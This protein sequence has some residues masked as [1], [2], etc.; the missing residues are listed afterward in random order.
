MEMGENRK[1]RRLLLG[2]LF[3]RHWFLC[4]SFIA[5]EKP[6][7]TLLTAHTRALSCPTDHLLSDTSDVRQEPCRVS[8]HYAVPGLHR[9]HELRTPLIRPGGSMGELPLQARGATAV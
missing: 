8:R 7:G 2:P 9:S 3:S 6:R 1:P 4:L 5:S